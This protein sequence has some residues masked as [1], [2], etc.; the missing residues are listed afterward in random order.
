MLTIDRITT[1]LNSELA[2]QDRMNS[3][4]ALSEEP[5]SVEIIEQTIQ[6]LRESLQRRVG[7]AALAQLEKL[8]R[9]AIDVAGTGGGGVQNRFNSST[10]SSFVV[11]AAGVPVVKFGNG[12]IT[13]TSGSADFLQAAGIP[14][15]ALVSIETI[16]R[17]FDETKLAFLYAPAIYPELASLQPLRRQLGRPTLFNF[18]GPLLNPVRPQYRLLGV[19]QLAAQSILANV[20]LRDSSIDQAL[21]ARAE[22]GIDEIAVESATNILTVRNNT[23]TES[24]FEDNRASQFSTSTDRLD[25]VDCAT[26]N[27]RL[28]ERIIDGSDSESSVF[29]TLL[30]NS[31]AALVACSKVATIEAGI[32][33]STSAIASGIV[34]KLY[35]KCKVI[36][37]KL[38]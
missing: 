38:S 19:S 27:V 28:F 2:E 20:L 24:K 7:V 11:A 22:N 37:G 29:R 21:V 17:V 1:V 26:M 3:L 30:L 10:A 14:S 13:G 25:E 8:G 36:Y 9:N 31:A 33:L 34:R 15:L 5:V 18:I 4:R 23:I 6:L 32:D 12:R 16:Q 35:D